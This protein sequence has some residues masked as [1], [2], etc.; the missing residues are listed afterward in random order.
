[1][2][3][4]QWFNTKTVYFTC[5]FRKYSTYPRSRSTRWAA[6]TS[7]TVSPSAHGTRGMSSSRKV[8]ATTQDFFLS[9]RLAFEAFS[10]YSWSCI[11]VVKKLHKIYC[12]VSV[13]VTILYNFY[14]HL[15]GSVIL[16][17]KDSETQE[18][19]KIQKITTGGFLCQLQ[20]NMI[21]L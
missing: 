14:P 2:T 13:E 20:V 8:A 10:R 5:S 7:T 11:L 6:P 16:S 4:S 9:C 15:Q 18:E 12:E 3:F 1:M 17:Q 19:K 21:C